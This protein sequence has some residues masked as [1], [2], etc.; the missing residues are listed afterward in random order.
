M[1]SD[2]VWPLLWQAK[3]KPKKTHKLWDNWGKKIDI[4]L[5]KPKNVSMGFN[6]LNNP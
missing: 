5:P 6:K 4:N 2:H 3:N 1:V